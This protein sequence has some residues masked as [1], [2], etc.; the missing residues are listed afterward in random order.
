MG[1]CLSRE[2]PARAEAAAAGFPG[3]QQQQQARLLDNA[4]L[5]G[6][7]VHQQT[8]QPNVYNHSPNRDAV[9]KS[10]L[11]AQAAAVALGGMEEMVVALYNYDS[12]SDGDLSFRKGDVMLLMDNR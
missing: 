1:Q 12:R 3:Q 4:A 2:K 10:S 5:L 9:S 8:G 11:A 6:H 7:H